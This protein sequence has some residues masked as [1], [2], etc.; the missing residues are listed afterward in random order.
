ME[1]VYMKPEGQ[2]LSM[3]ECFQQAF[4]RINAR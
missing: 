1:S 4:R 3:P 2:N